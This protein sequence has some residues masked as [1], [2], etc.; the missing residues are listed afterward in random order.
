[1]EILIGNNLRSLRK[2]NRYSQKEFAKVI[3]ISPTY[4]SQIENDE[5][6]LSV[7]A[8]KKIGEILRMTLEE[9]VVRLLREYIPNTPQMQ[10]ML[11]NKKFKS[12]LREMLEFFCENSVKYT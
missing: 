12:F 6:R 2:E 5:S 10:K 4:L 1:M 7:G 11:R 3:G 8:I 9:V